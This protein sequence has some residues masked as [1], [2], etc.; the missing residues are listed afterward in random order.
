MT[1]DSKPEDHRVVALPGTTPDVLREEAR[2][3]RRQQQNLLQVLTQNLSD[4]TAAYELE[5]RCQR[6]I[7]AGFTGVPQK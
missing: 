6:A 5:E 4:L 1:E 3:A 7:A 2:L